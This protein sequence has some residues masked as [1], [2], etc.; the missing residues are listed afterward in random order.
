METKQALKK[1]QQIC[2]RQEKCTSD[3]IVLLKK[4]G[5]RQEEHQKILERLMTERFIDEVRYAEA[6]VRDKIRFDHWGTKK[7]RY[8]LRH[9]GIDK[10]VCDKAIGSF[11]RDEYRS[12][13]GKELAKKRKALK[14]SSRE[15]W[16]KLARYG[17]SRGYEMEIMRDFLGDNAGD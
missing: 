15:I 7:I 12:L 3:V 6:F 14:G 16:A 9:K 8:F 1:L 13:I 5:I 4:W 11:D 17:S 2:S 10:T